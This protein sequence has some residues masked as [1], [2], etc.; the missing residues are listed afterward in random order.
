MNIR[1]K[2]NVLAVSLIL[3]MCLAG[4]VYMIC[5]APLSQIDEE[6]AKLVNVREVLQSQLTVCNRAYFTNFSQSGEPMD[7]VMSRLDS[8]FASL[9][10]VQYL[11]KID[12]E[13]AQ[14]LHIIEELYELNSA[15]FSEAV[16][17]Y[18]QIYDTAKASVLTID[19]FSPSALYRHN[20]YTDKAV[21]LALSKY[22]GALNL[23]DSMVTLSSETITAQLGNIDK[24]TGLVRTRGT[25][26]AVVMIVLFLTVIYI[27][28]VKIANGIARKI[29]NLEKN[30]TKLQA[31]D[32][33]I[34]F[35]QD[36]RDELSR[37]ACNLSN[38]VRMLETSISDIKVSVFQNGTARDNLRQIVGELSRVAEQVRNSTMHTNERM[39][40]LYS[41]IE[42]T[43]DCSVNIQQDIKSLGEKI[44]EQMRMFE[45]VAESI[46]SIIKTVTVLE[47]LAEETN[48]Y[49]NTLV[50]LSNKGKSAV[51]ESFE[52]I[53]DITV[54][55][56]KIDEMVS[57]IDG[58]AEQTN[59]LAMNA[60]I[61][62]AHAGDVG[63]GFAV[64]AEEIRKLAEASAEGSK[65]ISGFV[66][67][68][69]V[70][71]D[72]ARSGSETTN[73]SFEDMDKYIHTVT[74]SVNDM[75]V[76]LTAAND[77]G[78]AL[79]GSVE[80]L[81]SVSSAISADSAHVAGES[82]KIKDKMNDIDMISDSVSENMKTVLRGTSDVESVSGRADD[83]VSALAFIASGLNDLAGQFRTRDDISS[84]KREPDPGS[85]AEAKEEKTV[86]EA[87]DADRE[88]VSVGK[89]L[90]DEF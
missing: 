47:K 85:T 32:L 87:A 50:S 46:V 59:I 66:R 45:N 80:L 74:D 60:A 23:L 82:E 21:Q 3:L 9:S 73:S 19:S 14:S 65:E 77:K 79:V 5:I 10:E 7:N 72:S 53:S 28:A 24:S 71:I 29:V 27:F 37:L 81:K 90:D 49:S 12:P 4:G 69:V 75:A 33:M 43:R 55:V 16:A 22:M 17:M 52:K 6:R 40:T 78:S 1:V 39:Q 61:E 15:R 76:R 30:I 68:I 62:A 63:K 25:I 2:L 88:Y 64:V 57:I 51:A 11:R 41:G 35:E 67:D 70:S 84:G 36:G 13:I 26:I 83:I 89:F 44:A 42:D 56:N 34:E 48:S 58:I 8:T 20:Y 18:H 31:G 38:F 54:Q 86:P